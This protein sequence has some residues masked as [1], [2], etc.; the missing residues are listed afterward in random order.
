MWRAIL[1][2]LVMAAAPARAAQC[3][4]TKPDI[5]CNYVKSDSED[6]GTA[7]KRLYAR[8]G[9]GRSVALVVGISAYDIYPPLS[10]AVGDALRMRAFLIDE[11]G[12]D[13]VVTLTDGAA[14]WT[15]INQLLEK[16]LPLIVGP[17]DRFLFY[18]SG[19]GETRD[20]GDA[21]RGYLVLKAAGLGDWDQMIDMP[22]MRQ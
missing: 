19:H 20:L 1:L 11:A 10:A 12:F 4:L 2:A 18:F 8:S 6:W 16:G 22:R 9:F 7:F 17:R 14:S 15:R 21:K 3:D 13:Q 5:D